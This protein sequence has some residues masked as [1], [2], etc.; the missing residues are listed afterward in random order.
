MLNVANRLALVRPATGGRISNGGFTMNQQV[1]ST[2]VIRVFS[3]A[4]HDTLTCYNTYRLP[5]SKIYMRLRIQTEYV[6]S[7]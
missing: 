4:F 6:F 3:I 5:S 1:G 2:S 7:P